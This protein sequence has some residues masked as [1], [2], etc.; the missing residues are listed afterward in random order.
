M[1]RYFNRTEVESKGTVTRTQQAVASVVGIGGTIC[2]KTGNL[3][4]T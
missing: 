3:Q 4:Q 1:R 2:L